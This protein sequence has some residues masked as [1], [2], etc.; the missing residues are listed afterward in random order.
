MMGD[1]ADLI[2]EATNATATV[3]DNALDTMHDATH[4]AKDAISQRADSARI[5]TNDVLTKNPLVLAIGAIAV[6]LL[7]G[8][9]VPI[10]AFER[11]KLG[12]VGGRLTDRAKSS[13][14][15][16]VARGKSA[17]ADTVSAAL[18]RSKS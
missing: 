4:S 16:L 17:M 12:P 13:A 3:R 5:A 2:H 18:K 15:E 1:A 14:A 7:A 6:G 10:S 9:I 8:F 11:E